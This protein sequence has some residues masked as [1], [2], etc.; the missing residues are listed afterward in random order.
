[1]DLIGAL[2][3][4]CL[5]GTQHALSGYMVNR[6]R[7]TYI[8]RVPLALT[9][10]HKKNVLNENFHSQ[11]VECGFRR[12]NFRFGFFFFFFYFFWFVLEN[13]VIEA[14]DVLLQV[15]LGEFAFSIHIGRLYDPL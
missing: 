3:T 10:Y 1:M 14:N 12:L 15:S 4:C 7:S 2:A 13:H 5:V 8:G 6:R 9:N 11:T